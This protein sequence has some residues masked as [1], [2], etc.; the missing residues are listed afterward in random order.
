MHESIF[1]T[2]ASALPPKVYA[3]LSNSV[4]LINSQYKFISFFST[5]FLFFFCDKVNIRCI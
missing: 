4:F 5:S 2:N 1:I 3:F